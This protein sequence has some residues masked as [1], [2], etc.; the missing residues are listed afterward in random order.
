MDVGTFL[1]FQQSLSLQVIDLQISFFINTICELMIVRNPNLMDGGCSP[2]A[3]FPANFA[4]GYRP[5]SQYTMAIS[6]NDKLLSGSGP[7][8]RVLGTINSTTRLLGCT[9]AHIRI[10]ASLPEIF[11]VISPGMI[12]DLPQ[13]IDF[14]TI[15]TSHG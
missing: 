11:M 1:V 3:V 10:N 6:K 12:V 8:H 7:A 2:I 9:V 14:D 15:R 4:L 5:F 13:V